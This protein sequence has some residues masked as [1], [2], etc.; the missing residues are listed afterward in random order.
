MH[1][2][3]R[4]RQGLPWAP[5]EPKGLTTNSSH[6]AGVAVRAGPFETDPLG[7]AYSSWSHPKLVTQLTADDEQLRRKALAHTC[8]MLRSAREIASFVPAGIVPA[9]NKAA[10]HSADAET[11]KLATAALLPLARDQNARNT[12]LELETFEETVLVDDAEALVT[13]WRLGAGSS[14]PVLLRLAC[15]V[16]AGVRSNSLAVMLELGKFKP[17]SHALISGGAVKLL[18]RRCV[19]DSENLAAVLAALNK[20]MEV[21]HDGLAEGIKG[22]AIAQVSQLLQIEQPAAVC[23]HALYAL[24]TLTV[25]SEEKKQCVQE[26]VLP[27]VLAL[28]RPRRDAFRDE[29]EEAVHRVQ[30]A[31]AALLMSLTIDNECK[32]EAVRLGAVKELTPL[33]QIALQEELTNEL[34]YSNSTLFA[35]VTKCIA[36]L[37]E[38]PAGRKQLKQRAL[39]DLKP[40]ADA[41]DSFVGKHTTIA[42]E[43]V[44]WQP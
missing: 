2:V 31:A 29:T 38:Y 35:N 33:V 40:L 28:V 17:G 23:E 11:R 18:V 20:V 34:D 10:E 4:K 41:Q 1:S 32:T 36:N 13:R 15:D 12:M 37:A 16:E 21:D 6:I 19:E 44:Q 27:R 43:K 26:K 30:T 22:G 3:I 7:L 14:V 39:P 8:E 5:E 42:V 9:L 24:M 25:G